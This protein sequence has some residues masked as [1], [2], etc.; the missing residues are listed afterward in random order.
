MVDK[1]IMWKRV[2]S[3]NW[4]PSA[5]HLLATWPC[6]FVS[7]SGAR[8]LHLCREHAALLL[9]RW[10]GWY[11]PC[12]QRL[13]R[14]R[15]LSKRDCSAEVGSWVFLT[16]SCP[17]ASGLLGPEVGLKCAGWKKWARREVKTR[18]SSV[19]L[20]GKERCLELGGK[21]WESDE[22]G[23]VKGE[24]R[25]I[26]RKTFFLLLIDEPLGNFLKDLKS[27]KI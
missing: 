20:E 26:G 7:L 22:K 24:Y 27:P 19:H 15:G 18:G 3:Q 12:A 9:G 2:W 17:N 4:S 13:G 5:H 25:E 10:Q 1:E 21:M 6:W 8:C 14:Q 16:S 11:V 23:S